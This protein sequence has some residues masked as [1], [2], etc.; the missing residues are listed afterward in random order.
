MDVD[1]RLE[2]LCERVTLVKGVGSRRRGELCIMSFVALLAG[3]PHTDHPASASPLI[4]NLAI[5]INDA[6]PDELR[7]R[8][9]PFAARIVGTNDGCDRARVEVLRQSLLTEILPRIRRDMAAGLCAERCRAPLE[10]LLAGV[11]GFGSSVGP[12]SETRLALL[13]ARLERG[14]PPGDEHVVGSACG[15]VLARCMQEAAAR[16]QPNWYCL[17]AINLLDRLCD[18]GATPS[19][20]PIRDDRIALAEGRIG[21]ALPTGGWLNGIRR[22]LPAG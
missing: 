21:G 18:V 8:L 4:R 6:M 7:Q 14:V 16:G 17:E 2:Q 20:Q 22:L 12:D 15:E 1:R 11:H 5:P 9:K 10:Y 13:L 3:E 19:R